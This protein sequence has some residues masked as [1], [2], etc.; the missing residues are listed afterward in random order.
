LRANPT[1]PDVSDRALQ[2][3]PRAKNENAEA[4]ENG[5]SETSKN[6]ATPRKHPDLNH[7]DEPAKSDGTP[8]GKTDQKANRGD[9]DDLQTTTPNGV[10]GGDG[11]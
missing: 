10:Q 11:V 1:K 4:V 7:P 5:T 2:P 3:P 8:R 6:T 9:T